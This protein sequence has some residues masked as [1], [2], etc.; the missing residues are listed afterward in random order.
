LL[1]SVGV[2][3]IDHAGATL[4]L[5]AS[6]GRKTRGDGIPVQLKNRRRAGAGSAHWGDRC[7]EQYCG[8]QL[9]NMDET[10]DG[11]LIPPR[12]ILNE[13]FIELLFDAV[14]V[15]DDTQ[16]IVYWNSGSEAIYGWAANEMIGQNVSRILDRSSL[17]DD[18]RSQHDAPVRNHEDAIRE[19]EVRHRHK[20]G[21]VL[22]LQSREIDR[23]DAHGNLRYTLVVNRDITI[24][25][26]MQIQSNAHM[27]ELER[28]NAELENFA[29]V[30]SHDLREPLRMISSYSK[31]LD[32]RYREHLDESGREFLDY[33]IDG[34]DRMS[35][36]IKDLLHVARVGSEPGN[37][38]PLSLSRVIDRVIEDLQIVI[39]EHKAE[40]VIGEM[41]E[42]TGDETQLRQVFQNLIENALKFRS[43]AS[44]KVTISAERLL[45]FWQVTV[46]DNGPGIQE[47]DVNRIFVPNVRGRSVSEI[48]GSGTGLAIARKLMFAHGGR[49]WAESPDGSGATFR[50]TFPAG[51]QEST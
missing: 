26:A 4:D 17:N 38:K 37:F 10:T 40:I 11:E 5:S 41:P 22:I 29:R 34:A 50:L 13:D 12:E 1:P 47:Q 48:F 31:L 51:R 35:A 25:R 39:A 21:S 3:Q 24:R 30:A 18:L 45:D 6:L 9:V 2:D 49:I 28:S 19:R 42:I 43:E 33:V 8:N 44:P 27:I 46:R 14:M 36:L 20:H 32:R 7:A 15:L 16:R 23:R